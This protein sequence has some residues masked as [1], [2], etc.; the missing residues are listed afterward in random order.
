[1][2][3][4]HIPTFLLQETVLREVHELLGAQAVTGMMVLPHQVRAAAA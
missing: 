1:M 4:T 2:M 3:P